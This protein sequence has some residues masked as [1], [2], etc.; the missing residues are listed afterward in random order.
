MKKKSFPFK[1]RLSQKSSFAR[2]AEAVRALG[3]ELKTDRKGVTIT[4]DALSL[5]NNAKTVFHCKNLTDERVPE[6][7]N[8]QLEENGLLKPQELTI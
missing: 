5:D 8:E 2:V 1:F 6:W 4:W 3:Y 7:L